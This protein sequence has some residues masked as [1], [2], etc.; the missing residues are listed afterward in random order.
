MKYLKNGKKI[1]FMIKFISIPF[2]RGSK[3]K[4]KMC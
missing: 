3:L 2:K 4:L 1:M